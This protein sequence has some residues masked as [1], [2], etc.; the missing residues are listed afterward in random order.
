M[1]WYERARDQ[2]PK[3]GRGPE[4]KGHP[5]I[6]SHRWSLPTVAHFHSEDVGRKREWGRG[7]RCPREKRKSKVATM[8]CGARVFAGQC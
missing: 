2:D 5:V 8:V 1:L 3:G 7:M 4:P 6:S